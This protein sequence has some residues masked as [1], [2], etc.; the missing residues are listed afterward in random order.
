VAAIIASR[1]FKVFL[2]IC[3]YIRKNGRP[4]DTLS[5]KSI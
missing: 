5:V 3:Q 2:L 1:F 4:K